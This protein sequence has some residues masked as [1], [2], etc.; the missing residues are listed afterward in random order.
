MIPNKIYYS[1]APMLVAPVKV[2]T[3][4]EHGES[5]KGQGGSHLGCRKAIGVRS[6][7]TLETL[8]VDQF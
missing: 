6:F 4:V 2:A 8:F 1:T 5:V 7:V 3:G